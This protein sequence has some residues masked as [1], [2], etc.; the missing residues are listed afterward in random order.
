M[1]FDEKSKAE[2]PEGAQVGQ[3]E[4]AT[5]KQS[6]VEPGSDPKDGGFGDSDKKDGGD[7]SKAATTPS[8]TR[9]KGGKG[10]AGKIT[11]QTTAAAG[12]PSTARTHVGVGEKVTFSA[13][14]EGT[15]RAGE[16]DLGTG[17]SIEWTAPPTASI[18]NI[19]FEPFLDSP[20]KNT[21]A[22]VPMLVMAPNKVDFKKAGDVPVSGPGM[23]GVGMTLSVTIGP[24]NVSFGAAEWLEQPGPAEGVSGYFAE[25][26][27]T[28]SLA[29]KP[30]PA[31]LPMGDNNNDIKDNAWT[32]DKPKLMHPTEK[33]PRWWA[34]SF[35]WNIP[36]MY[37]VK[38]GT[39]QLIGYVKQSFVMDDNG[40]ITVT[41]GGASATSKPDNN[42]DGDIEKYPTLKDAQSMLRLHGRAGCVQ[43]VM[44][45]KRNPKAD[46]TSVQN[47]IQA[48]RLEDVELWAFVF[49]SNKFS[50]TDP[51][52]VTMMA[53]GKG[54]KK[55]KRKLKSQ[56][57]DMFTYSVNDVFNLSTMSP[58]DPI[59][60]SANI[61]DNI[62]SHPH[63]YTVS[64]PY[65]AKDAQMTGSD[66][67]TISVGFR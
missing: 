56:E 59:V 39:P 7:G 31:W 9:A 25:Y 53:N 42:M 40:A 14:E 50:W 38:G 20:N 28:E 18:V 60:F 33:K 4:A 66:R 10:S 32:K 49:C 12:D 23:A 35:S 5:G 57:G 64:Y 19:V 62:S 43:A 41:K 36:N 8:A 16:K 67:Y 47:L 15:W 6:L 29:H 26:A 61:E 65:S 52:D 30:N 3:A 27:K 17:R 2:G 51:D 45:Y 44:N 34:G 54:S 55:G 46:P 13:Q 48:L 63:S 58:S 22:S 37:R 1:Q 21:Q 24:T 11:V